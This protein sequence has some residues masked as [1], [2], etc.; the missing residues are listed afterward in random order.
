MLEW[1]NASQVDTRNSTSDCPSTSEACAEA[2]PRGTISEEYAVRR[3]WVNKITRFHNIDQDKIVDGFSSDSNKRFDN[4]ITAKE[5]ALQVKW[6]THLVMWLNPPWSLFSLVVNKIAQEKVSC[7]VIA[8]AWDSK[9][10]VQTL[11]QWSS[12]VMFFETGT[13]FFELAGKPAGGIRWGI[14]AMYIPA[15]RLLEQA[16]QHI[17]SQPTVASWSWSKSSRRRWRRQQQR[18]NWMASEAQGPC[19]Q[20]QS[21]LTWPLRGGWNH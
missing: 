18:Y 4:H 21:P 16:V 17:T 11:L 9:P 6:P 5:D 10:W 15:T 1:R 3:H 12:K 13:R 8:P 19:T 2:A 7:I 20:L 14:Y